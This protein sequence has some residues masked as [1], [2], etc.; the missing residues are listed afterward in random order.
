M[1]GKTFIKL[2]WVINDIVIYNEKF[3][4]EPKRL[5]NTKVPIYLYIEFRTRLNT[6]H[7]NI[8][9]KSVLKQF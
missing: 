7:T 9:Y 6:N 8:A 5:L 3:L 1:N 4:L 2:L